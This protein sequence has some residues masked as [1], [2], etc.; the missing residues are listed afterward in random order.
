MGWAS[1]MWRGDIW[2]RRSQ[3]KASVKP[4]ALPKLAQRFRHNGCQGSTRRRPELKGASASGQWPV[5]N[6]ECMTY[7]WPLRT[8]YSPQA[9]RMRC[10]CSQNLQDTD[11][12]L[13][14]KPEQQL[15]AILSQWQLAGCFRAIWEEGSSCL[16][17]R[18]RLRVKYLRRLYP[19][20]LTVDFG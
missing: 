3:T 16:P 7:R 13:T 10:V 12:Q 11:P 5:F 6:L 19:V 2:G 8:C 4:L 17:D 9:L 14:Q 1:R 15:V 18:E 20:E